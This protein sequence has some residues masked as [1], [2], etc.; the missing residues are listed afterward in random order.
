MQYLPLKKPIAL[1]V[2]DAKY[3]TYTRYIG[4]RRD[5]ATISIDGTLLDRDTVEQFRVNPHAVI[6][7]YDGSA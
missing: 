6:G 5:V 7:H 4:K 1:V 2:I 3:R